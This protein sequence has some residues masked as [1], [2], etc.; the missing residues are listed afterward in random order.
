MYRTTLWNTTGFTPYDLIYDKHVVLPIE[1]EIK[2]LRTTLQVN[3]DLTEAQQHRLNQLNELDEL[4]QDA[5]QRTTL[6]QQQ[7]AR[8]HDKFIKIEI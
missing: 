8:W 1:F 5:I 2:T 6:V 4:R 3:L 7:R